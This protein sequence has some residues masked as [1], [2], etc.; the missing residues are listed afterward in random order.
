MQSSPVPPARR[1]RSIALL[2]AAVLVASLLAGSVAGVVTAR[3][4]IP[5]GAAGAAGEAGP[6][7]ESGERGAAGPAGADGDD[8]PA[9]PTGATGPAGPAGPRGVAGAIGPQ[10]VPGP[11][12]PEGPAG[13]PGTTVAGDYGLFAT[14]VGSEPGGDGTI[15]AVTF[16]TTVE[17]RGISVTGGSRIVLSTPGTYEVMFSAQILKS[18]AL[19]DGVVEIWF[20]RGV[21]VGAS[22]PIAFSNTRAYLPEQRDAYDVMTVSLLVTTTE[23]DEFIE[24]YWYSSDDNVSLV[25][26]PEGGGRPAIPAVILTVVPVG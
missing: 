19:R 22:T 18:G 14:H 12:G 23:A 1:A 21:G 6:Q 5:G 24:L 7:G 10:G 4:T 3:F 11:A 13:P 8:G 15:Q 25:T 16:D 17:A 26:I 20:Q 9:G 2:A